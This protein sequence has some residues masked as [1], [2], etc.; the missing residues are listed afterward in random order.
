[1]SL[2]I[3]A[4]LAAGFLLLLVILR[5]MLVYIPN[6]RVGILEKLISAQGLRP[7]PA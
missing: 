1:M 2:F 4:F 6:N 7:A 3:V 5:S